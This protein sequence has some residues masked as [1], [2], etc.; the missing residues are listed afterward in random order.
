MKANDLR[1]ALRTRAG[2]LM[3]GA[4]QWLL[5]TGTLGA[6]V[7]Y[8]DRS[9]QGLIGYHLQAGYAFFGAL[10]IGL[11]FGAT[12]ERTRVLS[13]VVLTACAAAAGMYAAVLYLPVW[14]GVIVSTSGLQNFATSRSILHFGL[15]L[16]PTGIGAVAGQLLGPMIPGGD[17]L[18]DPKRYEAE[19]WWLTRRSRGES[20][21][22]RRSP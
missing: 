22:S 4:L 10:V 6:L 2:M 15:M 13:V 5:L 1:A 16:V 11:L 18:Q 21:A 8:T 7:I 19:D 20:D 14:T 12:I 3:V 17:L 9:L